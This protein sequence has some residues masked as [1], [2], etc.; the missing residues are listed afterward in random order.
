L[1][2]VA[3]LPYTVGPI[4]RLEDDIVMSNGVFVQWPE[5]VQY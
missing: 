3:S 4:H 5:G 1:D 2:G